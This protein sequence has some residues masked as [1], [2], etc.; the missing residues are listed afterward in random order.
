MTESGPGGGLRNSI[1]RQVTKS[2]RRMTAWRRL[3]YAVVVPLGLGLIRLWWMSCRVVRVEGA[4]HL[5]AALDKGPSLVPC[6]VHQ[7]QLFCAKYS[8]TESDRRKCGASELR[9]GWLSSPSVDGEI[10]A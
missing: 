9:V 6:Y 5:Q 8:Q 2:G 3:L 10:G 7:H 1:Y 4:E